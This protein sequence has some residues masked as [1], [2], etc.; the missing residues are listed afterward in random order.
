MHLSRLACLKIPLRI[1][2]IYTHFSGTELSF[3]YRTSRAVL[4]LL[5][6]GFCRKL[7]ADRRINPRLNISTR[8]NR[9]SFIK[10]AAF[11][12]YPAPARQSAM[13]KRLSLLRAIWML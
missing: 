12:V 4:W 9:L 2:G 10:V 7:M 1:R 13:A 5:A 3:R 11:M 8:R 6:D